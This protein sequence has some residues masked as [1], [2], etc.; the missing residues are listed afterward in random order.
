MIRV[1]LSLLES[2]ESAGMLAIPFTG[3]LLA[4]RLT[5]PCTA[6]NAPYLQMHL[7]YVRSLFTRS[8]L[9]LNQQLGEDDPWPHIAQYAR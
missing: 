6:S 3:P 1:L 2:F 5:R 8:L 7:A 4:T 9:L